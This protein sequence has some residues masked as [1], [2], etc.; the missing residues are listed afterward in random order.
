VK[1]GHEKFPNSS[2]GQNFRTILRLP[3]IHIG[4][5]LIISH[6]HLLCGSSLLSEYS[7][8]DSLVADLGEIKVE[9][10]PKE[11]IEAI[12]SQQWFS[13]AEAIIRKSH[14]EGVD[15]SAP[16]RSGV[17]TVRAKLDS[18]I[19]LLDPDSTRPQ[20][21]NPAF[22]WAQN[23]TSIF[24]QLKFSRRFNAPGAL[25]VSDL[26]CA[27]NSTSMSL[28]ALGGHSGKRY[29]Y[30][31]NI[32]LW[33]HIDPDFSSWTMASV[34]KVSITLS[35][36]RVSEWPRLLLATSK[37]DNMH[38]WFDYGES[39]EG[40]LSGLPTAGQSGIT[41]G[42]TGKYF[43]PTSDSCIDAC[44][45]C[46]GKK[47]SVDEFHVCGGPPAY[48]PN[49]VSFDDKNLEKGTISGD[50]EIV[51]K[52]GPA[53]S[54]IA[55]FNIYKVDVAG[56][57]LTDSDTAWVTSSRHQWVSQN[58]TRLPIP[59][60]PWSD[61]T[62]NT[63][64]SSIE[65]I[66]VPVNHYGERRERLYRF[67]LVDKYIPKDCEVIPELSFVDSDG[68]REKIKG[69][70]TITP[71]THLDGAT[72]WVLYWGRNETTRLASKK[73]SSITEFSAT[74]SS[75]NWTTSTSIPK[76]ATH[77]L[78][79]PK[80][81]GGE[82]SEVLVGA[83]EIIDRVKPSNVSVTNLELSEDGVVS[84]DRP[85]DEVEIRES[86]AGYTVV[87]VIE[88]VTKSSKSSNQ[89]EK[90]IEFIEISEPGILSS[91]LSRRL[92]TSKPFQ[93]TSST[94]LVKVCV[95]AKNSLGRSDKGVC[96]NQGDSHG[97]EEL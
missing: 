92:T 1:E 27:F 72:Q 29:E 23:D 17:Q 74:S 69:V 13:A 12:V 14:E 91:L 78:F 59:D 64:S 45:D 93:S 33:D 97:N 57:N 48:G 50:L 8:E 89:K 68:D 70:F 80:G 58:N 65:L 62:S 37:I 3:M 15:I 24:I 7:T 94:K 31:L 63:S 51:V 4:I 85:S 34:G 26:T 86:V 73:S 96:V 67:T 35:K 49:D 28:S 5:I 52:S 55:L 84:F 54:D 87:A 43:C 32:D 2:L 19:R 21:V 46:K 16:V 39:L 61:L 22:Q 81:S 53:Q 83:V 6:L 77:I 60:T 11:D 9:N 76:D 20:V 82:A 56:T 40:S 71:P 30:I 79:Y 38:F 41:C 42:R 18:I 44:S 88:R 47:K 90:E 75:Y 36:M 66:V 95:Y 25:E 10:I